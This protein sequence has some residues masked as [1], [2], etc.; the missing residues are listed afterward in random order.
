MELLESDGVRPRQARYQAALR[1]DKKYIFTIEQ[2]ALFLFLPLA[3]DPL[4]FSSAAVV[5]SP[6]T[7]PPDLIF[8]T[9]HLVCSFL[10]LSMGVCTPLRH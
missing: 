1:P 5:A 2:R 9:S 6:A 8:L 7:G 10:H 3:Q 4:E